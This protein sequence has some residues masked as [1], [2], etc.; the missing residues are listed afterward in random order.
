MSDTLQAAGSTML[1]TFLIL[2]VLWNATFFIIFI[3]YKVSL[4]RVKKFCENAVRTTGTVD[5]LVSQYTDD[6]YHLDYFSSYTFYNE[7]G[8]PFHGKYELKNRSEY[9][10]GE[11]VT[12]YYDRNDPYNNVCENSIAFRQ[13]LARKF[14]L[15]IPYGNL[16]ILAIA[17]LMVIKEML[18]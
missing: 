13:Q 1:Y 6:S 16:F 11:T 7:Y 10:E 18:F 8:M 14:L 9:I 2:F 5:K 17:V 12:V 15:L 3:C 4:N